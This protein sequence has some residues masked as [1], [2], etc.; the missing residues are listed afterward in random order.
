[1]KMPW[2]H[3]R[4]RQAPSSRKVRNR[5]DGAPTFV[6]DLDTVAVERVSGDLAVASTD[7]EE[8]ED[9]GAAGPREGVDRLV[10]GTADLIM[11]DLAAEEETQGALEVDPQAETIDMAAEEEEIS[12]TGKATEVAEAVGQAGPMVEVEVEAQTTGEVISILRMAQL[13]P[14]QTWPR[15][16]GEFVCIRVFVRPGRSTA[17]PNC[18]PKLCF[19]F[20]LKIKLS[21]QA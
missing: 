13:H 18:P 21:D 15:T 12:V 9:Q 4:H 3:P 8:D 19:T 1:M 16:A 20:R 17:R 10:G 5:N 6:A 11:I 14:A 7:T 2:T